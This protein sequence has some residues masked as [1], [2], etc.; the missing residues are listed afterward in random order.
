MAFNSGGRAEI[1]DAARWCTGTTEEEFRQ[2]LYVPDMHDPALV[3]RTRGEMRI[4]NFPLWQI[5]DTELWVTPTFWPDFG[6]A[7]LYRAIADYQRRD[8]RF[9]GV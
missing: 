1:V 8:R 4:T 5:A 7:D 3:I 6:P 9:G 2:H